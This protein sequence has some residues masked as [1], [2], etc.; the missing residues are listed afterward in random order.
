METLIA[1][2]IY[3]EHRFQIQSEVI[4]VPPSP[5]EAM[6]LAHTTLVLS[7]SAIPPPVSPL[8]NGV[9]PHASAAAGTASDGGTHLGLTTYAERPTV[10]RSSSRG[11]LWLQHH[12]CAGRERPIAGSLWPRGSPVLHGTGEEGRRT[13][14][15]SKST[16]Q[17]VELTAQQGRGQQVCQQL[18]EK[19]EE[20]E[21]EIGLS[22]IHI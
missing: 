11:G 19:F 17:D 8:L 12:C 2:C 22:L 3:H 20:E 16:Q 18:E 1:T 7:L 14:R 15:Y 10:S 5:C 6:W 21:E 9:Q 4:S 13:C